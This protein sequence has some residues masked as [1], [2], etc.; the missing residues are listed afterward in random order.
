[1]LTLLVWLMVVL[2]SG[3]RMRSATDFFVAAVLAGTVIG[4]SQAL[5]RSLYSQMI[6]PGQESEYF[7][8]AEVCQRAAGWLGLLAFGLSFQLT[9]SYRASILAMAAFFVVGAGLLAAV[10]V[11]RAV[12]EAAYPVPSPG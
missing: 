12:A 11:R 2:F 4:G 9:G 8:L 10:D 6:P 5:S 1:M 7:A 3:L